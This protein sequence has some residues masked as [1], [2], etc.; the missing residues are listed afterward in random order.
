MIEL[1]TKTATADKR[2]GIQRAAIGTMEH[3]LALRVLGAEHNSPLQPTAL[4]R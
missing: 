1:A 3:L 4:A 2:I